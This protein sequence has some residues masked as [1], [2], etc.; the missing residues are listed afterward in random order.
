MAIGRREFLRYGGALAGIAAVSPQMLSGCGGS[1]ARPNILVITAD[2][3]RYDHLPYL[4]QTRAQFAD[5]SEFTSCRQNVS[6]CQPRGSA[7]SPANT[8]TATGSTQ[9]PVHGRRQQVPRAVATRRR[10]RHGDHRQVPDATWG[11]SAA[12][13]V[14]P[15]HLYIGHGADRVRI[16]GVRREHRVVAAGVPHGL[17]S[18]RRSQASSG[19]PRSRGFA[20]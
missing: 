14:V 13:V 11:R 10:L 8:R 3:M 17:R 6:L 2:D 15:A 9:Q 1:A 5:G 19:S 18:R 16:H 7:S 4:P 20:G 12:W